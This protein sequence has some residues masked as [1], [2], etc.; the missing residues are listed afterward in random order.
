M[1]PHIIGVERN[2]DGVDIGIAG[3]RLRLDGAQQRPN[4]RFDGQADAQRQQ[5]GGQIQRRDGTLLDTAKIDKH[6]DVPV[7]QPLS[8][9]CGH[10]R[11]AGA[12]KKAVAAHLAAIARAMPSQ[13][14][15]IGQARQKRGSE[16]GCGLLR[17]RHP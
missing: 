3:R 9:G 5:R 17:H 11:Q 16:G 10:I 13:I 6:G 15:Q 4:A 12:A 7:R 1:A 8:V 14:T 2:H